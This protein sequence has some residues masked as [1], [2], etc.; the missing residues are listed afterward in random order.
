MIKSF[1]EVTREAMELPRQKRRALATFLL[2][3]EDA[4]DDP[5]AD[6]VW[7]DEVRA[8]IQ[9]IDSG[10]AQGVPYEEVMREAQRRLAP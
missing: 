2:Q 9:A 5:G 8:R 10:T 7:E 3:L 1:E 4:G 6:L